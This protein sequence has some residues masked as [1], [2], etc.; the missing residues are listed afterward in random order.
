[1]SGVATTNLVGESAFVHFATEPNGDGKTDNLG[2]QNDDVRSLYTYLK[3]YEVGGLHDYPASSLGELVRAT[4]EYVN[5]TGRGTTAGSSGA[6]DVRALLDGWGVP[7]D[8]LMYVKLERRANLAG[9]VTWTVTE[10]VPVLRSHGVAPDQIG[11]ARDG[12]STWMFSRPL[13]DPVA[14][15]VDGN[16]GQIN[17]GSGTNDPRAGGWVR[18]KAVGD[19]YAYLPANDPK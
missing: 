16:S 12:A 7:F 11:S 13:P 18:A 3:T 14:R 15:V 19:N 17:T 4:P 8:Y 1:L 2:L 9:K 6:F 10:R 5:P